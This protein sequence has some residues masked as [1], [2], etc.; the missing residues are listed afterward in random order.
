ME[1]FFIYWP[2]ILIQ[3]PLDMAYD[4][5]E[6]QAYIVM[7]NGN[8]VVLTSFRAENLQSWTEQ[9]TDG[10]FL[11]VA[12]LGNHAYFVIKRADAYS[13]ECFD[14]NLHTDSGHLLTYETAQTEVANL[15]HLE[16]KTVSLTGDGI[17]LDPQKVTNGVCPLPHPSKKIE[18]G[19]PFVHQVIPLP[20]VAAA[21]DGNAPVASCRLVR[22]VLRLVN[23]QSLEID[24]G[25]GVHQELVPDLSV[26]EMDSPNMQKT[27][28]LVLRCLG[29]IRSPTQPLWEI[30]GS[31]PQPFKLVSVTSDIKLGG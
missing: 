15:S 13:L 5:Y 12:I 19:L 3:M 20:P 11:S 7:N 31:S 4:K 10:A 14:E 16:G 6:R 28:D 29:W 23:T 17:V 2:G 25:T 9:I 24:T 8:L 22:L 21:N 26:Y 18:I 1:R 30:K 27:K